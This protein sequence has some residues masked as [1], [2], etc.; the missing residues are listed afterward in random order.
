MYEL[1]GRSC[2]GAFGAPG[3]RRVAGLAEPFLSSIEPLRLSSEERATEALGPLG[4]ELGVSDSLFGIGVGLITG[5][6]PVPIDANDEYRGFSLTVSFS[7]L[8]DKSTVEEDLPAGAPFSVVFL[9]ELLFNWD[10]EISFVLVGTS[11]LP[12]T[13]PLRLSLLSF[14]GSSSSFLVLEGKYCGVSVD[15]LS[16]VCLSDD[17]SFVCCST[18]VSLCFGASFQSDLL[19]GSKS[20]IVWS[21]LGS[22]VL[23]ISP[24]LPI[25]SRCL[26]MPANI[27]GS[28]ETRDA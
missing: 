4:F 16:S 5:G 23:T 3:A 15:S 2:I 19:T 11:S 25:D 7:C 6:G 27:G 13:T 26:F 21:S 8:I 18:G 9:S 12:T 10:E 1:R 20:C 22:S 24:S 28:P 17:D 14:F